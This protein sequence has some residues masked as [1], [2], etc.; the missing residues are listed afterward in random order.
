MIVEN[1]LRNKIL[2]VDDDITIIN[3][4][5]DILIEK[6]FFVLKAQNGFEALENINNT[7]PDLIILDW[8]MPEM[9]GITTLRHL[10][11]NHAT[12]NIPVIMLTGV[13]TDSEYLNVAF[14]NGAFDFIRKHF[15]KIEL[16]SRIR[17]A[18]KFVYVHDQIIQVKNN[19]LIENALTI[20]KLN[21]F[22]SVCLEHIHELSENVPKESE[23]NKSLNNLKLIIKSNSIKNHW[24]RFDEHFQS[25]HSDFYKN[26][27]IRHPKLGASELKICALLKLNLRTK[28]IADITFR[29]PETVKTMR[30]RIR[31]KL[32]INSDASLT[33]YLM[34]F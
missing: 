34:Q 13:M 23:I 19:E 33:T 7:K 27:S 32:M 12:M 5:E 10:N 26:L 4:L 1:T 24:T 30:A 17:A 9:D 25:I 29:T 28:D 21:K 8:N 14:E 31:K 20:A 18:L 11:Q 3:L 2:I 6:G 22:T 16:L 15:D